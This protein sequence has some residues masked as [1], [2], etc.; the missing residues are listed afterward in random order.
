MKKQI[1][2]KPDEMVINEHTSNDPVPIDILKKPLW[3]D[4]KLK[5]SIEEQPIEYKYKGYDFKLY[6][7]YPG[8]FYKDTWR[9]FISVR[10]KDR[11]KWVC[12]SFISFEMWEKEPE[13]T[14]RMLAD[15]LIESYNKKILVPGP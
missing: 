5:D 2:F 12:E 10:F 11:N 14:K 9:C 8:I 3:K 7:D 4:P 1:K 15:D 13:T 6:L